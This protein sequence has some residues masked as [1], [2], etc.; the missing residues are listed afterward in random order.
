[1]SLTTLQV[2]NSKFM[3]CCLPTGVV[4]LLSLFTIISQSRVDQTHRR[5]VWN[6]MVTFSLTLIACF[7]RSVRGV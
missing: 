7:S 3:L 4:L 1:M 5:F 6:L 2:S